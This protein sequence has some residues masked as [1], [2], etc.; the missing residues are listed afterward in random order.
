MEWVTNIVDRVLLHIKKH[1]KKLLVPMNVAITDVDAKTK[2][3]Q[4]SGEEVSVP[5]QHHEPESKRIFTTKL[6]VRRLSQSSA[7]HPPPPPPSSLA[8]EYVTSID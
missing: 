2:V 5:M 3:N 4:S 7:T 6:E 8:G 1:F